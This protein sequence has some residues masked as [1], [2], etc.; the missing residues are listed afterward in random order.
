MPLAILFNILTLWWYPRKRSVGFIIGLIAF[1]FLI[2][3]LLITVWVEVPIDNQIKE[4]TPATVQG[5]WETLRDRWK[6]FH[7]LRTLTAILTF[8]CF[9][10]SILFYRDDYDGSLFVTMLS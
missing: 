5:D 1:V 7:A 10:A 6:L 8:A 9:S 4:W 3:T 2:I